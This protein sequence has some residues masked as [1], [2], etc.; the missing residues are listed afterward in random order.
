MAAPGKTNVADPSEKK[1]D[2]ERVDDAAF[3]EETQDTDVAE[4]IVDEPEPDE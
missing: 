1:L 3:I 2:N 4:I